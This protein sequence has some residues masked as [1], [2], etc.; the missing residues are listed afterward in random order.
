MIDDERQREWIRV[1]SAL[2]SEAR[3]R[4]VLML[5]EGEM[6]CQEII[7]RVSLS[8]PAI[9]YHLGKLERAGILKKEKSGSRN[10]YRLES[11]TEELIKIINK[12]ELK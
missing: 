9:S 4:M 12:E 3:L 10:C 7:D 1:F 5:A 6:E 2:A 8:Q 11:R